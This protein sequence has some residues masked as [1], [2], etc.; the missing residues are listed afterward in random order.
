MVD[1][2]RIGATSDSLAKA[3][4]ERDHRKTRS[5]SRQVTGKAYD[6]GSGRGLRCKTLSHKSLLQFY[7]VTG[8]LRHPGDL[9]GLLSSYIPKMN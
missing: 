5:V 7:G 9:P 4:A 8:L 6:A 2:S 1:H 3:A